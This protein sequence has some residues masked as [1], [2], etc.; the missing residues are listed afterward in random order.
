MKF[1]ILQRQLKAYYMNKYLGVAVAECYF[2]GFRVVPDCYLVKIEKKVHWPSWQGKGQ[3]EMP[4]KFQTEDFFSY[5]P[6]ILGERFTQ[7]RYEY[8]DSYEVE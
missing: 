2:S 4:E 5:M 1:N 6:Y 7:W 8:I 3:P